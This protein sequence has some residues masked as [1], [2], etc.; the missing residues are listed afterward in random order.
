MRFAVIHAGVVPRRGG[1]RPVTDVSQRYAFE[2]MFDD[3]EDMSPSDGRLRHDAHGRS[4]SGIA[5]AS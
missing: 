4:P 5:S 3:V 1:R 2:V